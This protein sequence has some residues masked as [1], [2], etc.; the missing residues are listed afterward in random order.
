[1]ALS[2]IKHPAPLILANQAVVF[3]VQSDSIVLPLRISGGV[4]Q[5]DGDYVQADLAKTATFNLSDYLQGLIT[6]RG[7]TDN[8]PSVYAAVP[9][10]LSFTF[11][12]WSGDPPQDTFDQET[13][14]Y[15]LIDAYVPKS[16]RLSVYT[17][18][19]TLLAYLIAS[20]S[21]L[22][23]FPEEAKKVLPLQ[24]DFINFLQLH[25]PTPITA[26]L[27]ITLYF[28]DGTNAPAAGSS[29]ISN[30]EYMQLGYFPTGFTQLGIALLMAQAYP[31]KTLS[32]YAVVVLHGS[33]AISKVYTYQ[34]DENWYQYPRIL[35]IT[36]AYGLH[37]VVL[38]TGSSQQDNNF[39]F[40]TA[41]T[42]GE[43]LPDKITWKTD[44]INVVKANTG[45]LTAEQLIWFSDLLASHEAFEMINSVLHP[46]VITEASVP[47]M[48]DNINQYV[49]E[50]TYEYTYT[51]ITE[52]G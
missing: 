15:F 16:K 20:K 38:C 51:Q 7:K 11:V 9:Q 3:S 10:H 12:E 6:E 35:Y 26:T 8:I 21:C 49:A 47:V 46:I 34:V 18:Y 29:S 23:W 52:E 13:E 42:N 44:Q 22:S 50:F 48:H 43:T 30:M 2:I 39:T 27:S 24:K 14:E 33:T 19:D 4:T 28:T 37:E 45:F 17:A 36:N 25:S 40:E 32:S 41:I 31:D 1:M 5:S